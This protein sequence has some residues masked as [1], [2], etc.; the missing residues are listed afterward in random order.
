MAIIMDIIYIYIYT[1]NYL[2]IPIYFYWINKKIFYRYLFFATISYTIA[3]VFILFFP[4]YNYLHDPNWVAYTKGPTAMDDWCAF[5]SYHISIIFIMNIFAY[6]I[7]RNTTN[8]KKIATCVLIYSTIY[9][10]LTF[11]TIMFNKQHYFLDGIGSIG[12]NLF[13]CYIDYKTSLTLKINKFYLLKY[14]RHPLTYLV[15]FY[16]IFSIMFVLLM[17]SFSIWYL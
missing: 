14:N 17:V 11:L 3:F 9:V 7:W 1:I 13:L 8:R 5:P 6:I 4:C 2:L 12:L 15:I 16:S 10:V